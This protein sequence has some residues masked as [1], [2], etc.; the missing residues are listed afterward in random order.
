[1]QFISP[2]IKYIQ[3]KVLSHKKISCFVLGML[4]ARALPP[5]YAFPI[6][7]LTM[8]ALLLILNTSE[9]KK[10]SFAFGYWFGFG[11]FACNMAWIGNAVLIEAAKLGWLFPSILL[12]AGGFFGLFVALPALLSNLP[13][14]FYARWLSFAAWWVIF[15]WIRSFILTGFPWNLLGSVLAFDLTL[16]QAASVVGT[17]GLSLAILLVC[18]APALIAFY[19]NKTS[20]A[21]AALTILFISAS[22]IGYGKYHLNQMD[23]AQSETK[24]R[25]V[26]PAIPQK[27]KWNRQK[28]E[29]NLEQYINM[30]KQTGLEEIDFVIWGE[31]ATPF[32]LDFEPQYMEKITDA[33]PNKGY[34]I[35]GLVRYTF[36][37]GDFRPMNSSFIIDKS[38]KILNYYDKSHL[39]PFGEYIPFRKHLPD[40]IKPVTNT[41]SD[42]IAGKGHKSIKISTHPS[43]GISICYEIIFPHQIINPKDKPDWLINLTNDGWYGISQGPYQHLVTTQLRAIEEGR[44]IVRAANTGISAIINPYGKILAQIPL[45]ERK[46]LDINLPKQLYIKTIYGE[47]GNYLPLILALVNI[48]IVFVLKNK[49]P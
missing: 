39:V 27:M 44:T 47:Y 24:I 48:L 11:Y 2:A 49:Q 28:L 20:I 37:E 5:F 10:Q 32:A 41:I 12:A 4:S 30:S 36:Q 23:I 17:Y 21:T 1:M 7:F 19:K 9:N 15:E 26:Q 40:W 35:T 33:I 3:Q 6:L 14:S 46:I 16:L 43:F 31:T 13:K 45:N 34:L 22:L 29:E 8:S 42:F 38:G 25:L 18:C